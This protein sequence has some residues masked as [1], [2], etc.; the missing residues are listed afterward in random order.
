VTI[1]ASPPESSESEAAQ[2]LFRE[3]RKRRRRRWLVTGIVAVVGT[4]GIITTAVISGAKPQVRPPAS[5]PRT[6]PHR[7][8]AGGHAIPHVAWVDNNG[9]L[10][11]GDLS[12][13]TQRVVTPQADADPAAP[14]VTAGGR[15][16]WVR[17][18]V[19]NPENG[20]FTP[21]AIPQVFG[22][23]T[24]TGKTQK[25]ASG[26]QVFA[27][28]DRTFLYVET[29]SRHLSEYWLNGMPRGRTL[30]LP[31]GWFLLNPSGNSNLSP[32]IAN[33]ILVVSTAYPHSA[34]TPNDGTLAIWNPTN[35]HV[36]TLGEAWQLS[37]TYTAPGARSSLIAWY[38]ISQCTSIG[39]ALQITTTADYSSR[40][41]SSPIGPF[42]WGGGFSPDGS[43]LAVFADSA[44]MHGD[45]TAQLALVDTRSGALRLV[46]GVYVYVGDSVHWADWLPDGRRLITGHL[47][48]GFGSP[49]PAVDVLVD[50]QTL[51]VSPFRFI[52]DSNQDLTLST[53]VLH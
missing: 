24:A 49:A 46:Q 25:I 8:I 47:G 11:L 3:A 42:L 53:V 5:P 21:M 40:L 14:L 1:V 9:S 10:H 34:I 30:R 4:A 22:F 2:L 27:S 13:F 20:S 36:R 32:A 16:F 19:P 41:V 23:N 33:G 38:P 44:Y 51:Q 26:T 6:A 50:S 48:G 52:A 45:P 12:G 18:E 28:V 37:A 39:C 43:Q 29:D 17:S 15:V 35:G 31:A 7:P